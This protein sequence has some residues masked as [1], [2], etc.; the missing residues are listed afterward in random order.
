MCYKFFFLNFNMFAILKVYQCVLQ[1]IFLIFYL[2]E[3][4]R[5]KKHKKDKKDKREGKEKQEKDKHHSKEKH[6]DNDKDKEKKER[7]EK[8][9]HR[10]KERE[11][12]NESDNKHRTAESVTLQVPAEKISEDPRI[13]NEHSRGIDE[14]PHAGPGSQ[15]MERRVAGTSTYGESEKRS[16]LVLVQQSVPS[17]HRKSNDAVKVGPT[18]QLTNH[19]A[20]GASERRVTSMP[21][22]SSP[23]EGMIAKRTVSSGSNP[24]VSNF[25][26]S[27]QRKS[28]APPNQVV[29]HHGPGF[30]ERRVAG[31]E[32]KKPVPSPFNSLQGKSNGPSSQNTNHH[33]FPAANSMKNRVT[34]TELGDEAKRVAGNSVVQMQRKTDG[35]TFQVMKNHHAADLSERR[36]GLNQ[37]TGPTSTPEKEKDG[38]KGS[39]NL[40]RSEPGSV[41]LEEGKKE[42]RKNRD[43]RK[44][45]KEQKR[46]E[47]KQR[48]EKEKEKR[49]KKKEKERDKAKE[50]SGFMMRPSIEESHRNIEKVGAMNGY[51][52]KKRKE[53]DSNGFLHGEF[54]AIFSISKISCF[55]PDKIS[56][57]CIPFK[58]RNIFAFL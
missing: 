12:D 35:P 45:E 6:R 25:N 55:Q 42:K 16:V 54:Y 40:R 29:N 22:A 57:S 18:N 36:V 7:K 11:R 8:H 43:E 5:D 23:E 27:V 28:N 32:A 33:Q 53:G 50:V 41:K 30:T 47:K 13:L 48:K 34:A 52:S 4:H 49:E 19:R 31:T 24:N 56:L 39:L 17:V 1:I 51:L 15:F 20:T 58:I 26:S 38:E 46:L 37:S 44:K 2:Q 21:S 14:G 3:K 9:K 10:K